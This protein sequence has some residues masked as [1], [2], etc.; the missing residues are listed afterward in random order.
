[1]AMRCHDL[2][3]SRC[4]AE[5]CRVSRWNWADAPFPVATEIAIF[6]QMNWI[7]LSAISAV[8]LGFYDVTKKYAARQNAVPAVLLLSVTVGAAIWAPM[9]VWSVVDP[10]SIPAEMVRVEPLTWTEH[11][12]IFAKSALV[13]TSWTFSLFALKHL[14][15]S[16]AAPIRSTSPLWTILIA[17]LVLAERPT[18]IQWLGILIVLTAFWRFSLLGL[19]EGIRFSRDRWVACMLVATVLGAISSIYD[20]LLLQNWDIEPATLQSWFTVYLVPVMVPLAVR[21]F[22]AERERNPLRFRW[23]ILAISPLLLAADLVYFQ[24]IADEEALISVVSTVRRCSVVIAFAFGIR[25]FGEQNFR[26][27]A[28]CVAAILLGVLL[29]SLSGR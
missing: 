7:V 1:M 29:L 9:M 11:A 21:W 27:K 20:K 22:H 12:L 24:A 2:T 17:T 3:C 28:I 8:L 23:S 15:L 14:P 10:E 6:A 16:I 18:P 4:S 5:S 26:P 19:S 13:G 25:A